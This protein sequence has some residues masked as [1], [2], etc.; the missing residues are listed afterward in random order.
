MFP[1]L[2]A[3]DFRATL[4]GDLDG[5]VVAGGGRGDG[6]GGGLGE[7]PRGGEGEENKAVTKSVSHGHDGYGSEDG[8]W[9][10]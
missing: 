1:V 3:G 8:D 7:K 6:L 9:V 4:L 2:L 5:L 10:S